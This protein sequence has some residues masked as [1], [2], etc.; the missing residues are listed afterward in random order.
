MVQYLFPEELLEISSFSKEN[1]CIKYLEI[2]R[3]SR[4]SLVNTLD[5]ELVAT[6]GGEIAVK[7]IPGTRAPTK[8]NVYSSNDTHFF[9]T[10]RACKASVTLCYKLPTSVSWFGE[11]LLVKMR[12]FHYL[13]YGRRENTARLRRQRQ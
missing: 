13:R 6:V 1:I 7:S 2:G 9:N 4:Q 3:V 12:S 11:I 10:L 5:S 8:G